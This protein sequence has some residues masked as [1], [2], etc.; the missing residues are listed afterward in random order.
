MMS[1]QFHETTLYSSLIMYIFKLIILT[2]KIMCLTTLTVRIRL[3][4]KSSDLPRE[5]LKIE[6]IN[7]T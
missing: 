2:D 6:I 7:T 1:K 3:N 5:F 4:C